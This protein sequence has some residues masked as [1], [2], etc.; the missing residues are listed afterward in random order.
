MVQRCAGICTRPYFLK[1]QLAKS[2]CLRRDR[3]SREHMLGAVFNKPIVFI[4]FQ[5]WPTPSPRGLPSLT[6]LASRNSE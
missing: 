3:A 6:T 1:P 2:T 4:A 5:S